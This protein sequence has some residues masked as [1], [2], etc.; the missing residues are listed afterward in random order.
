MKIIDIIKSHMAEGRQ[1]AICNEGIDCFCSHGE[2]MSCE[3]PLD[4]C[5]VGWVSKDG[6]DRF[7]LELIVR[8]LD[9]PPKPQEQGNSAS[10]PDNQDAP[11]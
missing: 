11:F 9:L 2:I 8:D 4:D 10:A 1:D 7:S 5:M 6:N 3:S